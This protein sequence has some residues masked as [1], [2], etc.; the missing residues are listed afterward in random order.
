MHICHIPEKN[1]PL[2]TATPQCVALF[3]ESKRKLWLSGNFFFVF[4]KEEILWAI[5]AL[6]NNLHKTK[7]TNL[8]LTVYSKT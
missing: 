4:S 7:S 3:P 5:I 8:K 1:I 6:K 2:I